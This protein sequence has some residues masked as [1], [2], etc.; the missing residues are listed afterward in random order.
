MS[1]APPMLQLRFGAVGSVISPIFVVPFM[2]QTRF[3]PVTLSRQRMSG[4][5]SSL[6]SQGIGVRSH[7]RVTAKFAK[8][9]DSP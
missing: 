6:K 1:V 3:S 2:S 9:V 5:A 7:R 8:P 4:S